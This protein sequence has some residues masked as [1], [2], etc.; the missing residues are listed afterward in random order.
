MNSLA[1]RN[2]L[3]VDI[4]GGSME[5][6]RVRER[7]P[8][9]SVTLPAGAV[10]LTE[11]FIRADPPRPAEVRALTRYVEY[12]LAGLSWIE[13]GRNDV[14]IGMGGT[15]RALAKIDQRLRGYPLYRVHGYVLTLR[16][17]EDILHDLQRLPLSK[18]KRIPGLSGDRADVI[19]GGAIALAQ[20][21]R[22]AGYAEATVSGQL[23]YIYLQAR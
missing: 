18:R 1:V 23:C 20:V 11:A 9:Q 3:I 10:R 15:I 16:A 22:R 8:I 19:L 13:A 7:Q 5:L 17:I 6:S 2:G 4:G 21:M 12:M 14:L